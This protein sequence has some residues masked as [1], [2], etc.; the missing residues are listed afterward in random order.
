MVT[1]AH[2]VNS[3]GLLSEPGKRIIRG[4]P[5]VD[6]LFRPALVNK[7]MGILVTIQMDN[8]EDGMS[9]NAIWADLFGTLNLKEVLST[10]KL[11]YLI[12]EKLQRSHVM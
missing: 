7:V 8:N 3:Q 2:G 5:K 9:E 12:L 11:S 6:N 4:Q 10:R 1:Q